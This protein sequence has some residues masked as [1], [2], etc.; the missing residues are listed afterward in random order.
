MSALGITWESADLGVIRAMEALEG[1]RRKS[2]L[3]HDKTAKDR[4]LM[5]I[6]VTRGR[7]TSKSG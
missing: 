7:G 6:R 5:F 4:A 1:S 2:V 3:G